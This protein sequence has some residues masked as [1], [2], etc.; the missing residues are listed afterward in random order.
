M[1][2][3]ISG[4]EE[5]RPR[6]EPLK[7][8]TYP[9]VCY[10]LVDI[11]DQYSETFKKSS[12]QV[13]VMWEIPSEKI[14]ID[15][16][17]KSRVM[18]KTYTC[19]LYEKARLRQDLNAW[20]GRDFTEAELAA[21]DLKNIVGA[22]CLL[23]VV[24]KISG[25]R[26]Y[27]NVG[28]VVGLGKGMGKPKGTLEKVVFDLDTDPLEKIEELPEWIQERIKASETYK[29]RIAGAG[30]GGDDAPDTDGFFEEIDDADGE[31]PF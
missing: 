20:R 17:Q 9:A 8:G 3:V 18:S 30:S 11:G 31:L 27:A 6:I 28:G 26:V 4:I 14:E 23:T 2:L 12:H 15:G 7:G 10:G 13:I 16:E 21:F 19:S 24:Q 1:S 22:P 29:E 25:E 5:S